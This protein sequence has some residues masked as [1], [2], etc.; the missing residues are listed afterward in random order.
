[1]KQ[2]NNTFKALSYLLRYRN[3][4]HQ[5]IHKITNCNDSYSILQSIRKKLQQQGITLFEKP[6][7]DNKNSK[8]YWI[9]VA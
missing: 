7:P 5:K 1:M 9:E 8:Y 2:K 3:I 4:T 6:D